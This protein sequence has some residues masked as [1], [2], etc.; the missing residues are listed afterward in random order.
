MIRHLILLAT[1][2]LI[3]PSLSAQYDN[4]PVVFTMPEKVNSIGVNLTPAIVT[5]MNGTPVISRYS[6]MYKRQVK[7]NRSWRFQVNFEDREFYEE[8]R[9]DSPVSWS[10]T[11]ITFQ[12]DSRNYYNID[13]RFGTEWYKADQKSSMTYGVD[14]LVGFWSEFDRE[15]IRPFY[16]D[17]EFEVYVPSPFVA[18]TFTE[19]TITYGYAGLDFSIGQKLYINENFNFMIRWTPEV[20]YLWPMSETYSDQSQR[21]TA[22]SS[23][24]TFRLR[25]IE[26]L[27]HYTF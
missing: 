10:D 19:Q 1:W 7:P 21:S 3:A 5:V 16:L 18:E 27:L 2:L 11:T 26:G 9:N 12:Y 6:L 22:P 13:F 20:L 8:E 24:F 15:R 17:P 23:E 14:V 4:E 25:G